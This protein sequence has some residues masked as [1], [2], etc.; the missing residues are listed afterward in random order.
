MDTTGCARTNAGAACRLCSLVEDNRFAFPVNITK[1][2]N[3][4]RCVESVVILVD[5]MTAVS[6]KIK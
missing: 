3:A 1:K 6:E 2:I 5:V 4:Q